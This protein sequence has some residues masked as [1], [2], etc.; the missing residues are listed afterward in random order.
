MKHVFS[1]ITAVTLATAL[2]TG[3]PAAE[4]ANAAASPSPVDAQV[5]S[6]TASDASAWLDGLVPTALK[7]GAIP[8]AIVVIVKD[9]KVLV[10]KGYGYADYAKG[11]PVD[12]RVTLFR[13]G[14]TSK[15]FT[16]T[17]VMQM[18]EQGKLDLDT[19]I[20]QYLDFKIPPR[21]GKPM[22][23]RQIMK[24]Q[25][26]FEEVIRDLLEFN[27]APAPLGAIVKNYIPPRIFAA[28]TT[29]GYSN[30]ATAVAG[31]AVER[32]SGEPFND[33]IEH[34]IF[35]PLG[36]AHSTFRQPLPGNLAGQMSVG[37]N[38]AADPGKGF[39]VIGMSPAGA[40]ST[41]ADDISKFMIAHLQDGRF[42]DT[43]ILKPE[44]ARE[45]H[46]SVTKLLP[47]LPGIAL[48]FYEAN[49]NG[50][51]VIAHAGDTN[52]F[53]S[54][55]ALFL[56]DHVGIFI[57]SNAVGK[58]GQGEFL[59]DRIFEAFADRYFPEQ[60]VT[61]RVDDATARAH[62]KLMAGS[63]IS[64]R[65]ADSSFASL[66]NLVQQNDV[67][68]NPDGTITTTPAGEKETFVEVRPFFWRQVH[69]HD[70]L[71][72]LMDG[73]KVVHWGNND[74]FVAWYTHPEGFSG[75]GLE[76][77]IAI[78]ALVILGFAAL[79]WPISAFARRH[80]K[81]PETFTRSQLTA[82]RLTRAAAALCLVAVAV[83]A[84]TL[85]LVEIFE[86]KAY[87]MV[88]V[89]QII[90][91]LAFAGG[92]LVSLW[93]LVLTLQARRRLIARLFDVLLSA[94]FAYL[95]VLALTYHMIGFSG[96]F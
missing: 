33:Y 91:L 32:V 60:P 49:I 51:R 67:V 2:V 77:P 69:G 24:Q 52:Y 40:L 22:T 25:S 16:W 84:L 86:P 14:S 6:L 72:A 75:T 79:L 12:P 1:A 42:G 74:A 7:T 66:V 44:T 58:D 23:L 38:T 8:G 13:P 47:D 68:A 54:D 81:A 94:C 65:R 88:H 83:W 29:P 95:L 21:D 28:G 5:P 59:R 45:M 82:Y 26:G 55:L 71:Q 30:Y 57:S 93:N 61:A 46:D 9:G 85:Q 76:L 36:M 56:D 96:Q 89:A 41:T 78:G 48:G 18:V 39:E 92:L 90:S 3:S 31:Y 70:Q 64:T 17:A 11:T 63:Y 15:L 20:N 43:Q 53:H 19:D 35:T 37:Y 4:N 27:T 62:A 87:L 50:H 34:H 10:E 73:D 80:Y